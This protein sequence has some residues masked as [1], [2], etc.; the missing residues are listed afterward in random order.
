MDDM[1]GTSHGTENTEQDTE[2]DVPK[3]KRPSVRQRFGE[4]RASR[5]MTAQENAE[6]ARLAEHRK[7]EQRNMERN[8]AARAAAL[9]RAA[10][11]NERGT[12]RDENLAPVPRPMRWFGVWADRTVGA[13]PL[14]APLILSGY[15]TTHVFH[16]TG[17]PINIP[18]GFALI[19]AAALE[20]GV[21]KLVALLSKTMLEG[22]STIG[23]RVSLSIYLGVISGLIYWHADWVARAAGAENGAAHDWAWVPAAGAALFSLLGVRIWMHSARY[24]YRVALRDAGRVDKQAPKF[25][26]LAWILTPMETPKALRHAVRYRIESPIEAVED[27]RLWVVSGKPKVW[28]VLKD[29]DSSEDAQRS[30]PPVHV[31]SRTSAPSVPSAPRPV[32]SGSQRPALPAG[33]NHPSSEDELKDMEDVLKYAGHLLVVIEAFPHWRDGAV[34]SVR[35][36]RDAIHAYRQNQEDGSEFR[37]MSV[38]DKVQKALIKLREHP[39]LVDVINTDTTN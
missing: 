25:A 38:A 15:F 26:F 20:G 8:K 30:Q 10:S 23:L 9:S 37:S 28:P 31:P 17:Q 22:D 5:A 24:Q 12:T 33:P 2:Q 11:G 3:D 7:E 39:H 35:N 18:I 27:R 4:W 13:L 16:G 29:A 6:A 32:S 21:W 19:A 36:I 1:D 34:P 14:L